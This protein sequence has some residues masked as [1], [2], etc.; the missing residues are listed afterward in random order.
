MF[1]GYALNGP[2]DT[3][4]MYVPQTNAIRETRNIQWMKRMYYQEDNSLPDVTIDSLELLMR[5]GKVKK[6]RVDGPMPDTK[7]IITPKVMTQ[8]EAKN[9]LR[10]QK[11]HPEW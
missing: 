6:L 11:D 2:S 9:Q 7:P 1:V 5:S 10:Y 8:Q 3:M 4:R